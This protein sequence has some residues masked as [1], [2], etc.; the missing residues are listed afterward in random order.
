MDFLGGITINSVICEYIVEQFPGSTNYLYGSGIGANFVF[1]VPRVWWPNKPYP[2]GGT[3]SRMWFNDPDPNT[4]MAPTAP[5]ELYANFGIMGVIVGLFFVGKV[6]RALNT[7]IISNPNNLVLYL[8]WFMVIPDFASEWRGDF[9]AMTV[10]PFLRVCI[11]FFMA[12]LSGKITNKYY[13]YNHYDEYSEP[14]YVDGV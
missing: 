8:I 1:F 3:I 5:G 4:S 10:Q 9:G 7:R 12:W 6:V 11:F 2:T 14:Y 13:N